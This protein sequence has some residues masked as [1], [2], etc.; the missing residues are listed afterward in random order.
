MSA[1]TRPAIDT[2]RPHKSKPYK[3]RYHDKFAPSGGRPDGG[4][5]ADGPHMGKPIAK[6]K[7]AFARPAGEKPFDKPASGK[8]FAKPYKAK[9]KHKANSA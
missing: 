9:K 8:P 2:P 3:P 6:D 4:V 5:S 7:K 1:P